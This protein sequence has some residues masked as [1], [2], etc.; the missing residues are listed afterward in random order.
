M[1]SEPAITVPNLALNNG[2]QIPQLGLGVYQVPPRRTEAVV[3]AALE[4]GYRS[5]DTAT[6]YRNEVEVGAAVTRSGLAVVTRD[7]VDRVS[8]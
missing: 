2:V 6:L 5:I 3:T 7:V 4:T 8:P 1:H